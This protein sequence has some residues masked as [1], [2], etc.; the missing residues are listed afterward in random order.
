MS[1]EPPPGV[2]ARAAEAFRRT[3]GDIRQVLAAI[4]GSPEFW[5]AE[6]YRAKIKKPVELVAS[7]ARA[8]GAQPADGS[9]AAVAGTALARAA[10][11][12]GEA[13][14]EAPPPTG[15]GDTAAAWVSAGA[16]LARMNFALDLTQDRVRGVRAP[17]DSLLAGTD[18]RRPAEVLDRLLAGLLSDQA[19]ASTR[20]VL[21]RHLAD[22]EITRAT[23]DDRGPALPAR[24][25]TEKVAA[26]VLGSP[27]FQRR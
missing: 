27:E 20:A 26:L 21:A 16:L 18:G 8:V 11:A 15:Y 9:T 14:Y 3:D 1:D 5:S 22:P 19:T 24:T 23:S 17:V 4:V 10:G 13:L 7:A 6:A 12:L 2:V 25:D